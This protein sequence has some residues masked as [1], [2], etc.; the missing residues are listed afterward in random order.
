M[1]FCNLNGWFLIFYAIAC[2]KN[3][4]L[5]VQ[6]FRQKGGLVCIDRFSSMA[7][8]CHLNPLVIGF[9]CLSDRSKIMTLFVVF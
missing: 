2:I 3:K 4:D 6:D 8:R 1:D 5:A 7:G 9:N